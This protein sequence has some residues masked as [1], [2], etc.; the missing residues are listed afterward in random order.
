MHNPVQRSGLMRTQLLLRLN[1]RRGLRV[2]LA[3]INLAL[4]KGGEIDLADWRLLIQQGIFG[5]LTPL[6]RRGDDDPARERLLARCREEAPHPRR[7]SRR[8]QN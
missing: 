1:D 3:P 6:V 2:V 5:V 7:K 4:F 8:G